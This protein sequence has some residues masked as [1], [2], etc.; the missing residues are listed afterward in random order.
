MASGTCQKQIIIFENKIQ[1]LNLFSQTIFK[2]R[3]IHTVRG[4]QSREETSHVRMM[5]NNIQQKETRIPPADQTQT[6]KIMAFPVFEEVK[7]K[8]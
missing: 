6:L 7:D 3:D 1:T 4:K 5:R 2:F 8:I